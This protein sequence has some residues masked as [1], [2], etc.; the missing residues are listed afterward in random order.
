MPDGA[1]VAMESLTGPKLFDIIG[2]LNGLFRHP[3]VRHRARASGVAASLARLKSRLGIWAVFGNHDWWFDIAGVRA[4]LAVVDIPVL[5]CA[6][7]IGDPGKRSRLAGLGDQLAYRL[8]P[9]RFRGVDLP[10]TLAQ[11][12]TDDP[13]SW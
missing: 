8:G 1:I 5:E 10:R 4:A 7:L 2:N 3:S 11:V 9:H 13:V 12:D 6:V